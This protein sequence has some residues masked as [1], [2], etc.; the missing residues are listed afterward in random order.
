[1]NDGAAA[2]GA[3]RVSL[4]ALLAPA[5]GNEKALEVVSHACRSLGLG[6]P[7]HLTIDQQRRVLDALSAGGDYVATVAR[8]AKARVLLAR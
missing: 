2:R 5:L 3:A 4:D 8:F 7:A 6:D 1:M